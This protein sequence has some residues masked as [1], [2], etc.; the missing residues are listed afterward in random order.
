MN[1]YILG[2]GL[3]GLV[4]RYILG[5]DWK[6]IPF[7]RSRFYSTRPV[8]GTNYVI[9]SDELDVILPELEIEPRTFQF[10]RAFSMAGQ[11]IFSEQSFA[12]QVYIDK[13][14]GADPH[15]VAGAL[16]KTDI[17]AYKMQAV[18]LYLALLARYV[19]EIRTSSSTH[20]KVVAI[21]DHTIKTEKSTLEFDKIVST[22]PLDALLEYQGAPIASQMN[23]PAR[24]VWYYH[25]KTPAINLEGAREALVAD[26][27]YDFFKV[28]HVGPQEYL[29]HCLK[30]LVHPSKYLGAFLGSR[31]EILNSTSI[32]K[33]L[34]VG[35]PPS[36]KDLEAGGIY[37]IGDHGQWD[38]FMDISSSVN[39]IRKL[40]NLS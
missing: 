29:F 4:A 7:G 34:P 28:T 32:A 37:P 36:L 1:K 38:Q 13:V 35:A 2:S 26:T 33:A 10:T 16:T 20:G 25:V 12:K 39:R 40:S 17:T 30:D 14:F 18:E 6:L 22:I 19:D 9:R 5:D 24:D 27:P 21:T 11:L 23:L 3:T 15:P 8:L 31:L